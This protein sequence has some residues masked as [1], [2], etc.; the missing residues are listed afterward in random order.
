MLARFFPR[1]A[2]GHGGRL[3]YFIGC[4]GILATLAFVHALFLGLGVR[5]AVDWDM[6]HSEKPCTMRTAAKRL[7]NAE[8]MQNY[9]L[10]SNVYCPMF[11][12]A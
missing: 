1:L 6:N 8:V 3:L 10:F 2:S 12:E 9:R 5:Y 7:I 11:M 4:F